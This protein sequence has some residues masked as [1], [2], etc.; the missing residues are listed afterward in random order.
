[1]IKISVFN[2]YHDCLNFLSSIR[3]SSV[4]YIFV[5]YMKVKEIFKGLLG[6]CSI[7]CFSRIVS[8]VQWMSHKSHKSK[9]LAALS[10]MQLSN[11]RTWDIPEGWVLRS[12]YILNTCV[13]MILVFSYRE[14]IWILM[15]TALF[16]MPLGPIWRRS[17]TLLRSLL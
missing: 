13:K 17:R 8:L 7:I 12:C 16:Q 15:W 2:H 3:Q 10:P 9:Y 11:S 6:Q 4:T 1:M 5:Q 14:L